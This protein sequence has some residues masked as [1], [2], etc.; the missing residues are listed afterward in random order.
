MF[1]LPRDLDECLSTILQRVP[2]GALHSIFQSR[3]I[4]LICQTNGL[5]PWLTF[6]KRQLRK[7]VSE[8]IVQLSRSIPRS[9]RMSLWSPNRACSSRGERTIEVTVVVMQVFTTVM[10]DHRFDRPAMKNGLGHVAEPVSV[11]IAM[12][13]STRSFEC[14]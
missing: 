11:R 4:K 13:C 14:A 3:L 5:N 8:L 12:R 9:S 1:K 6:K 10:T 7:G 2:I